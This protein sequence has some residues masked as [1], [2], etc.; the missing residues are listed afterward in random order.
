MAVEWLAVPRR[1]TF[2][3]IRAGD[4]F[5]MWC[6]GR[7][8]FGRFGGRRSRNWRS[9]RRNIDVVSASRIEEIC[10]YDWDDPKV[11]AIRSI[12]ERAG[13]GFQMIYTARNEFHAVSRF[14]FSPSF[15]GI[16]G[17]LKKTGKEVHW[18]SLYA[19][20]GSSIGSVNN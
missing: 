16:I 7:W 14:N 9:L 18:P 19:G 10:K 20:D 11:A 12:H 4:N 17:R 3:Y 13:A 15:S 6:Y 2:L 1:D 8:C 5:T